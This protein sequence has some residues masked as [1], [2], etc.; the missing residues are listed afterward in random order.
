[1][2]IMNHV[3][4]FIKYINFVSFLIDN[5]IAKQEKTLLIYAAKQSQYTI[6]IIERQSSAKDAIA[7]TI[8]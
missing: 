7:I 2:A 6:R 4:D 1:M 3:N 5:G 8:L